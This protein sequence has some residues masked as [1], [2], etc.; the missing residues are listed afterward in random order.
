MDR[1][2]VRRLLATIGLAGLVVLGAAGASAFG[3]L[4]QGRPDPTALLLVL[5]GA[6]ALGTSGAWVW[7]RLL[8]RPESSPDSEGGHPGSVGF[9]RVFPGAVVAVAL[10]GLLGISSLHLGIAAPPTGVGQPGGHGRRG[11]PLAF[12]DDRTSAV[13]A[14]GPRTSGVA[15]RMD[16]RPIPVG[17]AVLVL[18]LGSAAMIWWVR[19]RHGEGA[20]EPLGGIDA[21]AAR[22]S[23]L[24]SIEAMLS[25][26]DPK[27]AI[28]GAYARLL[29]GLAAAGVPRHA[30]EA[31]QEHLRR[32]LT[33]LRV[34]SGPAGRLVALFEVA[35]FSTHS[36][37]ARHRDQ[38]LAALREVASELGRATEPRPR[39]SSPLPVEIGS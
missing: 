39:P 9:R 17:A 34:R 31:P 37:T 18:L 15:G 3:S 14:S 30:Y 8:S 16:H 5:A 1:L 13:L 10:I 4:R 26:P 19:K 20:G 23:I 33:R 35:R 12:E 32:A 28:I 24:R 21:E 25:D 38:A 6:V 27:T 29:E 2:L 36:L 22:G 11:R 7:A